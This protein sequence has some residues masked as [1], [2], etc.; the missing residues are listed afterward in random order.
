MFLFF[1]CL[2]MEEFFSQIV[3]QFIKYKSLFLKML[4]PHAIFAM[5]IS[6]F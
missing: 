3:F 6:F 1:F 4:L 5:N 2:E